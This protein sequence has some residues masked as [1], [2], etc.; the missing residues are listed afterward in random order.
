M[1]A[2][3]NENYYKSEYLCGRKAVITSAFDYYARKSTQIIR[4][5]TFGRVK[6]DNLTDEVRMC[7]CEIAE[8]I[9]NAE[10]NDNGGIISA[11]VGDESES[12]ENAESTRQLL[13]KNIKTAV[14]SWLTD[15][16]L[17]YRGVC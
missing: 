9:F 11:S 13:S 1:T 8:L 3:A 7:C 16:G 2:Y 6:N 4:Q 5:Y 17:L 12:Y 15:T 14:Y 10:Q